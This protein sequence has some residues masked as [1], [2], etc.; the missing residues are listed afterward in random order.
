MNGDMPR[1]QGR[2]K[3]ELRQIA[4][5]RHEEATAQ[6]HQKR[7]HRL[8]G[9]EQCITI[10]EERLSQIESDIRSLIRMMIYKK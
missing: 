4:E 5:E 6:Q 1:P 9:L 2:T 10:F 3:A 7:E 8:R